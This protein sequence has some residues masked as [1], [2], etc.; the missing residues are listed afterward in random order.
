MN[1]K[2]NILALVFCLN[3][4][5]SFGQ[6]DSLFL[7]ESNSIVGKPSNTYVFSIQQNERGLNY[8]NPLK[9][10]SLYK[11]E[12]VSDDWIDSNSS[13]FEFCKNLSPGEYILKVQNIDGIWNKSLMWLSLRV[14]IIFTL[15]LLSFICLIFLLIKNRTK[16]FR[17]VELE[18]TQKQMKILNDEN[19]LLSIT[20]CLTGIYN[21]RYLDETLQN[22]IDRA[23]RVKTDLSVMMIDVDYF[24]N[25]NDT[26]GHSQGDSCL[27]DIVH[28]IKEVLSR[29]ND[30]IARYGG[31]EFFIILPGTDLAGSTKV[32]NKIMK[33]L[34]DKKILHEKSP[35][36]YVTISIGLHFFIP[37]MNDI[38]GEILKRSDKALYLAKE[39]GKNRIEVV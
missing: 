23:R 15:F 24:K 9:S 17:L 27:I 5:A 34:N 6:P 18:N 31:E 21:R 37:T 38:Y 25:Y 33:S 16:S 11:G 29:P 13:S 19:K 39:K 28:S 30:F 4:A 12:G 32:A 10:K 1:I 7:F 3:T 8:M 35:Y 20:D 14:Q 36:K 26:Y 22:E 2:L